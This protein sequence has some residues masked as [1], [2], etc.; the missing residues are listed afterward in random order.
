MSG[1]K[2]YAYPA[3]CK[4]FMFTILCMFIYVYLYV[5]TCENM[6]KYVNICGIYTN[7]HVHVHIFRSL[8]YSHTHNYTWLWQ[9]LSGCFHTVEVHKKMYT[10]TDNANILLILVRLK[11][12]SK[13]NANLSIYLVHVSTRIQ[14]FWFSLQSTPLCTWGPTGLANKSGPG[15][16]QNGPQ[17]GPLAQIALD[18][19]CCCPG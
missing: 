11:W 16:P 2:C 18:R 19:F 9:T 12:S 14:F 5:N 1:R 10:D 3:D 13:Q 15:G 4:Y 17:S 8:L 6:W 7:I